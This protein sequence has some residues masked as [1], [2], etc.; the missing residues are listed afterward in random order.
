MK[1]SDSETFIGIDVSKHYLDLAVLPTE[2]TWR[3]PN[4]PDELPALVERL[5]A[6]RPARIVLEATGNLET[7]LVMALASE[8]LP[9]VVVNPRQVRDFARATGVLAKTD[10]LDSHVLAS[11][12]KA[13]RPALKPIPNKK[14]VVFKQLVAR[15]RQL[16]DMLVRER[17]HRR[18]ILPELLPEVDQM[19]GHIKKAL[20]DITMRMHQHLRQ[21][22][23]WREKEQLLLTVPGVGPT[24]ARTL[25][26]ELPELGQI[27]HKQIAALVGVAPLAC[28]SGQFRGKRRI[29][30]GRS[31]V[32]QKLYMAALVASR[33][34]PIIRAFYQKLIHLGKPAKVALVACMR[35]LLTIL[36]AMARNQTPW[37][38][39]LQP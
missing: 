12:A 8:Q 14:A 25:I 16:T 17:N 2:E 3:T 7:P 21:N 20:A 30:G 28:D 32:R 19:I 13:I 39:Q 26:A 37:N 11:F 18:S 36:N 35:K 22:P 33:F 9:V 15:H 31:S 34:N 10:R 4:H 1:P 23:L 24:V 6:L 38:Y 29:W 5:A 27:S